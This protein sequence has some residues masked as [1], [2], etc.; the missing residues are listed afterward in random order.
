[1]GHE[2][3]QVTAEAGRPTDQPT[4]LRESVEAVGR[5]WMDA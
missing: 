3:D 4:N 2:L 5:K 1:M